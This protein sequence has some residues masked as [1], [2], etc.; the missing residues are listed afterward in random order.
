MKSA[1]AKFVAGGRPI[2]MRHQLGKG[3]AW[4]S[5]YPMEISLARLSPQE[6]A[7][8]PLHCIYREIATSSGLQIPVWS[9]DPR[10]EV[11]VWQ[12]P[13]GRR[14]ILAVNHAPASVTAQLMSIK[15]WGSVSPHIGEAALQRVGKNKLELS[16][17]PC[18]VVGLICCDS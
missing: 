4:L 1:Q 15:K 3:H 11:G 2:V 16:F 6:L 7:E 14:L 12:H 18:E 10:V 17:E 9:S 8:H 13:D 5:A